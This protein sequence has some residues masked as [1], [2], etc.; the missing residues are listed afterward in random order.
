M[1]ETNDGLRALSPISEYFRHHPQISSRHCRHGPGV[2][3][4]FAVAGVHDVT[5]VPA[6]IYSYP[7]VA[8]ASAVA[9]FICLPM[10]LMTE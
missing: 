4:F 1:T 3:G 9:H 6:A 8:D 10:L 2:V 5:R 7:A